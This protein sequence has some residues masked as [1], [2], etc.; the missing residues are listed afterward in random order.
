MKI[1]DEKVRVRETKKYIWMKHRCTE[2]SPQTTRGEKKRGGGE[3]QKGIRDIERVG[4]AKRNKI[5]RRMHK[6]QQEQFLG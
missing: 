5:R 2:K 1:G 3:G 6:V 4:E